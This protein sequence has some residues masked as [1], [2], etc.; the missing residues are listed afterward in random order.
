MATSVSIL[1]RMKK[2]CI[3]HNH[4]FN[5]PLWKPICSERALSALTKE[6]IE[7]LA[8]YIDEFLDETK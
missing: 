8:D 1:I 3:N 7:E 6:D 4:C 5:C 2:I